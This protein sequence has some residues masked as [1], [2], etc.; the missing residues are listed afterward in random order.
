[1]RALG[2]HGCLF[3]RHCFRGTS[4]RLSPKNPLQINIKLDDGWPE[5]EK[6]VCQAALSIA[7]VKKEMDR[8]AGMI[9]VREMERRRERQGR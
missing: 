2:F 9:L 6:D 4:A 3:F 8:I 1:M 5:S 7:A